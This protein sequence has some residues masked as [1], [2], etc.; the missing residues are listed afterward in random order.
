MRDACFVVDGRSIP[1]DRKQNAPQ[2]QHYPEPYSK[3]L[4][5]LVSLIDQPPDIGLEHSGVSTPFVGGNDVRQFRSYSA[6]CDPDVVAQ[7]LLLVEQHRTHADVTRHV[8]SKG[9]ITQFEPK[10]LPM[11]PV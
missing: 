9:L 5:H 10:V 11:S 2:R 3:R 1:F 4:I 6:L 8:G 7:S